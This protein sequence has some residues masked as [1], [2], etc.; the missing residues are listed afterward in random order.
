LSFSFLSFKV[1]S[2]ILHIFR[3]SR[4]EDHP[5]RLLARMPVALI[6]S[7]LACPL[8]ALTARGQTMSPSVPS[9]ASLPTAVNIQPLLDFKNSDIKF[10][11]NALM[12]LLRDR[13]HE[14]WVL[15]AYPDPK[16][17]RPLIGAG[18]SLDVEA[19]Q[20]PQFDLLNPNSFLEPS[21]EQLWQAAGL[22]PERLTRILDRYGHEQKIQAARSRHRRARLN[23][24][25]REVTDQEAMQLLRISAIQAIHNAKAYCREFDQLNPHQQMALSQLVFQMGVNLEQFQDF[26]TTLN[27]RA[28]PLDAERTAAQPLDN[29]PWRAVQ[30]TLIDSQWA[31]LYSDRA[32][33]VIAMFDPQYPVDPSAAQHRVESV[34]RPVAVHRSTNRASLRK[35]SLVSR[36][37]RAHHRASTAAKPRRKLS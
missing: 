34:L 7:L 22:N 6:L 1:E 31:R 5:V 24:L 21:S 23:S 29:A 2:E 27:G 10:D 4:K 35:V 26:L 16:T 25:P 28:T 11:M 20:H 19:R 36:R 13:Q 8:A 12:S 32:A 37:P 18:F 30:A 17:R 14:G 33:S 3:Q 15:A 9:Q